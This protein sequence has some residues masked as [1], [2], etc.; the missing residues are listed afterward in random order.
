LFWSTDI[1][2]ENLSDWIRP[3]PCICC[4]SVTSAP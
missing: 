1:R 4:P 3:Q 2:Q